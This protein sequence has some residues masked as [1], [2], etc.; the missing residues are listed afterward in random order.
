M[1]RKKVISKRKPA[2][3]KVAKRVAMDFHAGLGA[4][5]APKPPVT[6][7]A[8]PNYASRN[9]TQIDTLVLHN[10]DGTLKSAINRFKDPASQVSAHYIV[11]RDASITQMVD[12]SDTAWHSGKKDVNQRSIGIEVVAYSTATGMTAS[13]QSSLIALAQFVLDAYGITV[14]RVFPHRDIK[15]TDCPGWVWATDEIFTAWTAAH[16]HDGA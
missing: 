3:K 13:Q 4:G 12:D 15:P 2:K 7:I 9:G 10:T 8:S 16:L 14:Q 6:F 11:D 1:A 5:H